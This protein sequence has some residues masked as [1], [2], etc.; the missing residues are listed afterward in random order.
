MRA[1]SALNQH[2]DAGDE[3]IVAA[4][5]LLETYSVLT[6]LPAEH[7]LTASA[8]LSAIEDSFLAKSMS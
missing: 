6:R 7:R 5:A 2:V 3:M 4:H 8:A 1:A